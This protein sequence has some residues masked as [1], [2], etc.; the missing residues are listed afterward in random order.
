MLL[1][2]HEAKSRFPG[3]S[4]PKNSGRSA[5]GAYEEAPDNNDH[6]N[7]ENSHLYSENDNATPE[8]G[9][10]HTAQ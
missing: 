10:N 7:A 8:P 9:D 3:M 6:P 2:N 5:Y 4:G 1:F